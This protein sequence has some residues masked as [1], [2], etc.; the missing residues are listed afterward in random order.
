MDVLVWLL[1]IVLFAAWV[2]G[3]IFSVMILIKRLHAPVW[4]VVLYCIAVVVLPLFT[5][6][7]FWTVYG[8]I[9]LVRSSSRPAPQ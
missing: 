4:A 1:W 6:A 9:W 8:I 3:G 2:V 7:V 5:V